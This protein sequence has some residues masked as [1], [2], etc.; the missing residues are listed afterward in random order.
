MAAGLDQLGRVVAFCSSCG[1]TMWKLRRCAVE[2]KQQSE[3]R[4]RQIPNVGVFCFRKS[5]LL[6]FVNLK[7][8]V[9]GKKMQDTKKDL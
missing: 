9:I 6:L 5:F 7:I 3:R 8:K 2:A 1:Q 4:E